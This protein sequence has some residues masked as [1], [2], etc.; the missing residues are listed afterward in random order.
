VAST[1]LCEGDVLELRGDAF[2]EG[3][4]AEVTFRGEV[5]RPGQPLA[6]SFQVSLPGRSVSTHSVA[7][8]VTRPFERTFSGTLD[9]V[10]ATFHGSVE[11]SF[12]P[13][14]AGTPPVTG[15]LP[16]VRLDFVPAEGERAAGEARALEGQRFAEFVGVLLPET[17]ALVVAGVMPG[18]A[19]EHAGVVQG[20]RLVALA[21]VNALGVDDLVPPPRA[22]ASELVIE[23]GGS[24]RRALVLDVAGF[25][26]VS[27]RDLGLA[28]GM[29]AGAVLL[30][31]VLASPLGRVL[32]FVEHRLVERV[33]ELSR[34]AAPRSASEPPP[35]SLFMK[36]T[37]L[38]PHGAPSYLVFVGV[39]A[40]VASLSLGLPLVAR[41]LDLPVLVVLAFTTSALA[42]FVFG[43]PGER[44]LFAR[45]RRALLVLAQGLPVL[46]ALGCLGLVTGSFG[47]EALALAQGPWPWQWLAFRGPLLFGAATL[48]FLA[49][50][51]EAS[52]GRALET[53]LGPA[54]P[55]AG[56]VQR[57]TAL[58]GQALLLVGS[59]VFALAFLG[60]ARVPGAPTSFVPT[61][62]VALAG[63]LSLLAK[64]WLV[65]GSV[66]ALRWVLGRVDIDE[67][68]GLTLRAALPAATL[69]F[70]LAFLAE[71]APFERLLSLS[72]RGLAWACLGGWLAL[73]LT[74]AIR[75][76][77]RRV[78]LEGERGPNPWL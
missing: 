37:G 2:P 70:G 19:A 10:H 47:A 28:A 55:K 36:V 60:G 33:R 43:A 31:L 21:G 52:R 74:L 64:T 12:A 29:V 35:P 24:E 32:S 6:Q 9:P 68:R 20:D 71:R 30:L 42:S 72:D 40:L 25:R 46:A 61:F 26:P 4:I 51:P 76:G 73:A 59:G 23:R 54:R 27:P 22:R 77:P 58:A 11:V 65:A 41:E 44:G 1:H 57:G 45:A 78:I 66:S 67:V 13:R 8:D 38:L 5:A 49:L 14:V 34:R 7:I 3:R 39:S 62:G 17:G 69:L 48:A 50:V 75:V 56:R 16:D 53:V 63:V 18:S 15:V